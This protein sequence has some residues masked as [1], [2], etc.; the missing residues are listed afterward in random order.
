M[1]HESEIQEDELRFKSAAAEIERTFSFERGYAAAS[2]EKDKEISRLQA[3]VERLKAIVEERRQLFVEERRRLFFKWAEE[4]KELQA[5][6]EKL[7]SDLQAADIVVSRLN[8]GKA[9][10]DL[11][12][13]NNEQINI[14]EKL[15]DA[16][17][18]AMAERDALAQSVKAVSERYENL[19]REVS[20]S[21]DLAERHMNE[22]HRLRGALRKILNRRYLSR[23]TVTPG[24][25][26]E[27]FNSLNDEMLDIFEECKAALGE[28]K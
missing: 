7:K 23:Q 12:R 13:A 28:D 15:S 24:N 6:V 27:V 22:K 21:L 3:E 26:F 14:I 2:A 9:L 25:A 11:M 8:G 20:N 10:Q 1:R 19:K 4:R 5:E 16:L 18:T 17:K